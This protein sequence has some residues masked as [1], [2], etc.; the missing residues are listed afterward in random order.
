MK[1]RKAVMSSLL[2]ILYLRVVALEQHR[3]VTGHAL[4]HVPESADDD[5]G[6]DGLG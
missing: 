2:L 3:L 4:T 1:V 6:Y 5:G